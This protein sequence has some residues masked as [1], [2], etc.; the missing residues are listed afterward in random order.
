MLRVTNRGNVHTRI[1]QIALTN[2]G[3]KRTLMKENTLTYVLPG[4]S[5]TWKIKNLQTLKHLGH[6]LVRVTTN[7]GTLVAQP[8][9][10]THI[11]QNAKK[12]RNA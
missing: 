10:G 7:W 2:P 4:Q 12:P 11:A 3:K 1:T 5:H 6:P 8:H 9:M